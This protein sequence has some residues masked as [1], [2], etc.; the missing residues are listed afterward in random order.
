MLPYATL[1]EAE[2]AIGRSLT[3]AETLWFNYTANKSDYALYCHAI[4]LLF[5][6]SILVPLLYVLI[7]LIF[8]IA[9]YKIQPK[10]KISLYDNFKCYLVVTRT[11]VLIVAPTLLVSYPS[12]KMI[13]IRTSLPLPSL[14]E[15]IAQLIIYFIIEDYTS[16]WLHRAFHIKWVYENIHKVHHEYTAPTGFTSQHAHWLET[17]VFGIPGYLGPAIVPGHMITF[18]LWLFL[19][20]TES[21]E[22]HSGYDL[23][24]TLKKYIPF[25]GGAKFHDYHHYVGGQS[26]SNFA[27]IFTYCDY[28][29]GT[30][31]G[32][33]YHKRLQQQHQQLK[34]GLKSD[35]K[36]IGGSYASAASIKSE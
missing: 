3:C 32:Y 36:Q 31:K 7:E 27:P 35:A 24:W 13:G 4:P 1:Q 10:I 16:Y 19:R 18:L 6:P 8:P 23:P 9:S 2:T 21:V 17:L 25:Y 11:F 14:T 29:Y 22:I 26:Q 12:I 33:K 34:D 5:L 15:I 20:H 28:I 30:D